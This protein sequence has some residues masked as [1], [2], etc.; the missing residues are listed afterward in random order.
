MPAV[1][2]PYSPLLPISF[3]F[4]WQVTAETILLRQLD[5]QSLGLIARVLGQSVAMD[6]A[7]R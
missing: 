4:Q 6:Q 7:N 5:L 3:S 1:P 2:G